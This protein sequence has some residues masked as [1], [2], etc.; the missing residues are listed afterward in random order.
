MTK[1]TNPYS[2]R[3]SGSPIKSSHRMNKELINE[4]ALCNGQIVCYLEFVY[5]ILFVICDL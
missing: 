5:C 3:I 1:I 4:P 2:D